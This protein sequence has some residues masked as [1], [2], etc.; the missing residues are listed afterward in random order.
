VQGHGIYLVLNGAGEIAGVPMRKL[1]TLYL[2]RGESAAIAASEAS[3]LMHFGLPDLTGV[4]M[5]ER[6]ALPAQAAE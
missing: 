2:A 1:T 3:E 4:R 5:P 6:D